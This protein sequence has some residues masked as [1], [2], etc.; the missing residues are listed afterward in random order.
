MSQEQIVVREGREQDFRIITDFV[1]A[2]ASDS[3]GVELEPETVE[4]AVRTALSDRSKGVYYVAEAPEGLIGQA[5]VTRECSDWRCC[6]YR[7]LQ[8]VY[9]V[10]QWRRK[11]VFGRIY[12]HILD[13]ARE[14]SAAAVR[15][16][17][18]RDNER[19][20]LAY[21]RLGMDE[22]GYMVLEQKL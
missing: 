15:L 12:R 18:N 5:L 14:A 19:A 7:W 21:R 17:V 20:L 9:V 11:G 3:E 10:P 8:S 13:R 1:V 4:A 16:Y 22:S 6:E 2:M